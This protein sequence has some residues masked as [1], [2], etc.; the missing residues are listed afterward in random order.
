MYPLP[1]DPD[2]CLEDFM[3]RRA[4]H[5]LRDGRA[6]EQARRPPS[7]ASSSLNGED[8]A[9]A[10]MTA[11]DAGRCRRRRAPVGS[12]VA[13]G[14]VRL[15]R[16]LGPRWRAGCGTENAERDASPPGAAG[17]GAR[18]RG[19]GCSR[20]CDCRDD[21]CV[22][23]ARANAR[24]PEGARR[25]DQSCASTRPSHAARSR[26]QA[27]RRVVW[28]RRATDDRPVRPVA[29]GTPLSGQSVTLLDLS[30]PIG[31]TAAC[32]RSCRAGGRATP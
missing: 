6:A 7:S 19:R 8:I 9:E 27:A 13:A 5:A 25:R 28:S 23:R 10:G 11:G 14:V 18:R 26:R 12:P 24:A 20:R 32:S 21:A 30:A 15:P 17:P 29:R 31:R 2:R 16:H 22:A 1:D 4:D 3:E